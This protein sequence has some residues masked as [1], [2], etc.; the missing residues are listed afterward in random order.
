MQ[1]LEICCSK[2]G[3]PKKDLYVKFLVKPL[4]SHYM[5]IFWSR[6]MVALSMSKHVSMRPVKKI[7]VCCFPLHC[8]E[9]CRPVLHYHAD[10]GAGMVRV[11]A[12][13]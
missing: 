10:H 3:S 12:L 7:F 1:V 11:F 5:V 9:L 13:I 2:C 6:Q 8:F 4:F